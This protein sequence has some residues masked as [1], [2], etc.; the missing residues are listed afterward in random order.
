MPNYPVV[1]EILSSDGLSILGS[2]TRG[3]GRVVVT[4]QFEV[5][6]FSQFQ[7]EEWGDGEIRVTVSAVDAD[8]A[9]RLV[10]QPLY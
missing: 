6:R 2:E 9:V 1:R 8:E 7:S 4:R 10:P 5:T 3:D